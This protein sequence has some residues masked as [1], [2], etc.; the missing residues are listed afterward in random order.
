MAKPSI[1]LACI[2]NIFH[3]DDAFG[4]EVAKVLTTR[5]LPENVKLVDFGIRGFDL[6]FALV[7][8]YDITIFVDAMQRNEPPGTIFVFK[9]DLSKIGGEQT[10]SAMV[11][12]HGLNP[13]KV[14]SM[15]KG[16]GAKF[17][18]LLVVGCEPENLGGEFGAMELSEPVQASIEKAVERIE[19]LITE[20]NDE[21]ETQTAGVVSV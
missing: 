10:N 2:G 1:L 17:G 14:L 16:M 8:G 13:M 21:Y 15:A 19:S 20:L 7:D 6:A 5:D 11:D 4:V 9:P 18:Q 12:T 3:G